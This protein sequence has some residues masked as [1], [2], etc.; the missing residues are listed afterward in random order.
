MERINNIIIRLFNNPL[1]VL[2]FA[3][4]WLVAKVIYDQLNIIYYNSY[5]HVPAFSKTWFLHLMPDSWLSF[6]PESKFLFILLVVCAVG[7]ALGIA[8]RLCLLILAFLEFLVGG[9]F[10]SLG[11]F[12]HNSSLSSQVLLILALVPGTMRIS[13]DYFVYKHFINKKLVKKPNGPPPKWGLNLI[14]IVLVLTYFTAGV[15]KIRHGGIKWLDGATLGFYL[16]NYVADYASGEQ[17][18][19][20][21]NDAINS[22][23]HWKDNIGFEAHT[24]GNYQYRTG[25][26]KL[27]NW[28]AERPAW[29][30]AISVI[31]ILFEFTWF[32]VFINSK[33]RNI[34]LIAA[35]ITHTMIGV[36][37]GLYFLHYRIICLC[38]LDWNLMLKTFGGKYGKR[39]AA[40]VQSL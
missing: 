19:L 28:V 3:L 14:L 13:V 26:K 31:T 20:I 32:I 34:Y 33:Y 15:S 23:E 12:D 39:L 37:M 16:E 24:Y 8:G 5:D 11:I 40:R 36:L 6:G 10:E 17:Q 1:S 18:L 38:L 21:A 35:F 2:R 27:A 7:A 4:P 29:V 22:G 30:I 9:T 25:F